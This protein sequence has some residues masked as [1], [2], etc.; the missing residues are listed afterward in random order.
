MTRPSRNS[1]IDVAVS[2]RRPAA[3]IYEFYRDFRNLP[4]FL[5]DVMSIE[6]DGP[7]TSHWT[8]QGPLGVRVSWVAEVTDDR[9]DELIRY[10]VKV[11]R[12][13]ATTWEIHFT[14]EPGTDRTEV[15]EVMTIPFA[16]F[17]RAGLALMGRFPA[18][19]VSANLRRL[20]QLME[21]GRVTD[22]SYAVAGKFDVTPS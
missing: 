15:R 1:T 19:E 18:E 4:K 22:C 11:F 12:G 17:A 16:R 8:I 7:T 20:K 13:L 10:E 5:G 6:L 2:I 3:D 14:P 21:D 9:A